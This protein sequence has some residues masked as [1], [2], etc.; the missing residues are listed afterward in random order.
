MTQTSNYDVEVTRSLSAPRDRVHQAFVDPSQFVQWYGPQGFSIRPGTIELECTRGRTATVR[1][2]ERG[3]SFDANRLRWPIHR[4]RR[5]RFAYKRLSM[6]R[7][8]GALRKVG[9]RAPSRTRGRRRQD[10]AG[11]AGGAASARIGR[12]GAPSVGRNAPQ[13]GVAYQLTKR[14]LPAVSVSGHSAVPGGR[15]ALIELGP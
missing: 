2:G 3:R 10:Q 15:R 6:G 14:S 5:E 7:N 9:V 11:I 13:A 8:S 4:S 12:H 1:D